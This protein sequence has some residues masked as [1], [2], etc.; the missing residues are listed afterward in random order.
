MAE[1]MRATLPP[2]GRLEKDGCK[3]A[4]INIMDATYI[5]YVKLMW[6]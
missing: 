5:S 6:V 2:G 1:R 4:T 3:D